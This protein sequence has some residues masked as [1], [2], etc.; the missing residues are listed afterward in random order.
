MSS[1]TRVVQHHIQRYTS[2]QKSL[3]SAYVNTFNPFLSLSSTVYHCSTKMFPSTSTWLPCQYQNQ[4]NKNGCSS[5]LE[6]SKSLLSA[7]M[8]FRLLPSLLLFYQTFPH[9]EAIPVL[10]AAK[11][12]QDPIDVLQSGEFKIAVVWTYGFALSS[13]AYYCFTKT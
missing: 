1:H 10:S 9:L 5:G 8:P 6:I 2:Q 4:Q 3:G 12:V 7:R 11:N 13:L